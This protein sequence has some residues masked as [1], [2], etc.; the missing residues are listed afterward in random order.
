MVRGLSNYDSVFS[1]SPAVGRGLG[2]N[3]CDLKEKTFQNKHTKRTK[4]TKH[5]WQF[6]YPSVFLGL[7]KRNKKTK[8]IS[9][10][11]ERHETQREKNPLSPG[12]EGEG[13]VRAVEC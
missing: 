13:D 1:F 8:R 12:G 11:H 10:T 2:I 7:E 9:Q 4:G 6:L 5:T 3:L